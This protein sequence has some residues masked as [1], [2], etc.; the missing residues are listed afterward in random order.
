M[1]KTS[2]IALYA[3]GFVLL[4]MITAEVTK[5]KA[6]N[7]RDSFSASDKIPL[8]CF[9]LYNELKNQ[10]EFSLKTSEYN[11]FD[12]LKTLDSTQ[13]HTILLINNYIN[14]DD[15]LSDALLKFTENGNTVF[16]SSK[17][18]YSKLLDTFNIE[19]HR[20]YSKFFKEPTVHRF[21]NPNLKSNETLFDAVIENS[22]FTSIDTTKTI[23]LGTFE[24]A[25]QNLVKD[26]KELSQEQDT[27]LNFDN[28]EDFDDEENYFDY[29]NF[30]YTNHKINFIKMP[31]GEKGGSFIIHAN[32]FALTNYHLLKGNE[33]YA[34]GVLA[35]LP[36]QTI[37]WDNYYKSGRRVIGS[38][39]RFIL[40]NPPLKWSFY[41]VLFGLL[42]FVIFRGKRTQ[43][44]IPVVKPLKN[45]T[46]DFTQTIGDLYYQ[47]GNFSNIIFKKI[48][49]F[50]EFVRT[51]YYIETSSLNEQFQR[52]LAIKSDNTKEDTKTLIEY[53][54]YLKS[55]STHSEKEL[56]ELNKKLETFTNNNL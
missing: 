55:K 30:D 36:K 37:I 6:I 47:N 56:I 43:R 15:N 32:P 41:L 28:D 42:L 8:G 16:V 22:F 50:L 53:I 31:V 18:F 27:D 45:A 34:A 12:Y 26:I 9:V 25:D 7:W 24:F 5:P 39:L 38:P 3:I 29:D 1:D 21:S 54:I 4:L 2:K 17:F 11:L 51:R 13:K 46:V 44:I 49:Y 23:V 40:S 33:A 20:G 14:L 19:Y 35:Y 10:S 52:K 48:E